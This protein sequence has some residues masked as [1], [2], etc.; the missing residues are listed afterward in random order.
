MILETIGPSIIPALVRHLRDPDEDVRAIVAA[1]L[2]HLHAVE[3]VAA[4]A[5]LVKDPSDVVRQSVVAAM[6]SLG[7]SRH[8]LRAHPARPWPTARLAGPS[9]LAVCLAE[10]ATG[11]RSARRPIE[12]AV[13]TL[14]TALGDPTSAVRA[15]AAL[16]LGRIG[17]DAAAVAPRL[18]RVVAGG[19]RN[20]CAATR[21][22]PWARSVG[23]MGPRW[24]HW[25]ICC[26]TPVPRSRWRRRRR[27]VL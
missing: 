5:A 13:A 23:K 19:G 25:W 2:G 7:R 8:G 27:W 6:G 18:I 14:E 11:P 9:D 17:P 21:P 16:A 22:R 3:T 20:R 10:K 26:A 24:P 1:A 15:Q 4:L 12:L